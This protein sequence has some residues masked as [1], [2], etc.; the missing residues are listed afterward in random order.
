MSSSLVSTLGQ[1]QPRKC[2]KTGA[3]N[4]ISQVEPDKIPSASQCT[5][6]WCWKCGRWITELA[7]MATMHSRHA[8]F[9]ATD[10]PG[11]VGISRVNRQTVFPNC[12]M[13]TSTPGQPPFT[14][15]TKFNDLPDNVKKTFEDIE[16]VKYRCYFAT[17]KIWLQST[18]PGESPDQQGP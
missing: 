9:I 5:W 18:H 11:T 1:S 16:Y 6:Q 3:S 4:L 13:M 14:K 15:S 7:D 17:L 8:T 10:R 2:Y 12:M